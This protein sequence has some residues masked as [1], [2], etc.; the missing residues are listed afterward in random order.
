MLL[1]RSCRP[2]LR[3]RPNAGDTPCNTLFSEAASSCSNLRKMSLSAERIGMGS[4][5]RFYSSRRP[6]GGAGVL[7][8]IVEEADVI[9]RI[10]R[11]A[12]SRCHFDDGGNDTKRECQ[13]ACY[14]CLMSYNNQYEA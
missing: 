2:E 5:G 13:A 9:S 1:V 12:L 7:R 10:A 14:E 3:E 8:R 4:T 11:E 6:K